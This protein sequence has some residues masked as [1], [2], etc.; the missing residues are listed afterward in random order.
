MASQRG[1][2]RPTTGPAARR[3]L[4]FSHDHYGHVMNAA[5]GHTTWAVKALVDAPSHPLT[6]EMGDELLAALHSLSELVKLC[7]GIERGDYMGQ[8]AYKTACSRI[9]TLLSGGVEQNANLP[10]IIP[11]FAGVMKAIEAHQ[12]PEKTEVQKTAERT[13]SRLT[14]IL[15]QVNNEVSGKRGCNPVS[16]IT[17]R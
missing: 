11:A 15:V 5:S 2:K 7:R 12:S 13:L 6:P 1:A 16:W 3:Q 10:P 4:P 14:N 17:G 8:E 9:Q